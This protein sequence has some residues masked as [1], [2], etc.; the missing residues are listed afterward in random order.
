MA[1]TKQCT[2]GMGAYLREFGAAMLAYTV[3]LPL[4]THFVAAN[5]QTAWR[6]PMALAPVVPVVFVLWAV[7]RQVRRMDELQRQMQFEA[8][9]FAFSGAALLT[10]SY[11]FLENVG[12]PHLSYLYVLP[13]MATLWGIG[14][15]VANYRYR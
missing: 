5:P 14:V 6:V 1:T 13:L 12:W 15:G 3:I 4:S 10:F 2:K 7:I 11:G 8:L 9:V